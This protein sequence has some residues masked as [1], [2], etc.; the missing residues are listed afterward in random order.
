MRE[1]C[2]WTQNAEFVERLRQIVEKHC[3]GSWDG[4]SYSFPRWFAEVD[5]PYEWR[6]CGKLGFGGKFRVNN[7]RN[8]CP[9]IDCYQEDETPERRALI[10]ITNAELAAA[11]EEKP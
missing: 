7:N 4:F 3:G 6:F 5:F 1:D 11:F 2:V 8:G 9:Y 10:E